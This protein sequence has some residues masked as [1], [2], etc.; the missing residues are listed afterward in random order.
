MWASPCGGF[1]CYRAQALGN[2]GSLIAAPRLYSTGSIVVV[3]RLSCSVAC[4]I[5][6]NQGSNLCLQHWQVNSL[7][8]SHE[9]NLVDFFKMAILTCV[10][11]Y[12]IVVLICISLVISDVEHFFMCLPAICISSLE[13]CLLRSSV[14]FSIELFGWFIVDLSELFVYFGD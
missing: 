8:L 12:L 9:G 4:G 2:V 10:R 5:F 14:Q 11:N 6:P 7:P 3:R 1:S 13:K